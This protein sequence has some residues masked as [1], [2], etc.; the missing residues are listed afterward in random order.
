MTLAMS[1]CEAAAGTRCSPSRVAANEAGAIAKV[2]SGRLA[3]GLRPAQA[4]SL[5]SNDAQGIAQRPVPRLHSP[6][7]R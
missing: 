7:N 4:A 5:G 1:R 3:A 6:A 2:T